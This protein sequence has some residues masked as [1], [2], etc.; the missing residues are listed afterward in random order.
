LFY[1]SMMLMIVAQ[2]SALIPRAGYLNGACKHMQ[3]EWP[4]WEKLVATKWIFHST[5][6]C[7]I[8]SKQW[9]ELK[10]LFLSYNSPFQSKLLQVADIKLQKSLTDGL[11]KKLAKN[12]FVYPSFNLMAMLFWQFSKCYGGLACFQSCLIKILS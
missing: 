2:F 1:F 6:K 4:R 12:R 10:N 8:F 5:G 9:F 3:T 11:H 7:L